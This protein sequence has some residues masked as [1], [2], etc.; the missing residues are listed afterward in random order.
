MPGRVS[1]PDSGWEGVAF[2]ET[3]PVHSSEVTSTALAGG[4]RVHGLQPYLLGLLVETRRLLGGGK[5]VECF[6]V[7]TRTQHLP[8]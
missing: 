6:L 7:E 3:I 8:S 2:A 5:E 4:T 1:V